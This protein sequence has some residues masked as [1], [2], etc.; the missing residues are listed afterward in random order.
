MFAT[1][2]MNNNIN[3][4]K[5]LYG[6][7]LVVA[8]V[9]IVPAINYIS[10]A[11]GFNGPTQAPPAGSG[12]LTA[13][14]NGSLGIN[15]PALNP[16]NAK[17]VITSPGAP[18]IDTDPTGNT[19]GRIIGLATNAL[20]FNMMNPDD[21]ASKAYVDAQAGGGGPVIIYGVGTGGPLP[22]NPGTGVPACS[23]LGTGYV[24]VLYSNSWNTATGQQ[25]GPPV[26]G[27]YGPFGLV[28]GTGF[29]G[30]PNSYEFE[31]AESAGNPTTMTTATYSICSSVITHY[32]PSAIPSSGTGFSGGYGALQMPA[33][34]IFSISTNNMS[35]CNT[36][37]IC[38]K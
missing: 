32:I 21:A 13:L 5:I 31:A 15:T 28:L 30:V 3:F 18:A 26:A 38:S 34:N 36:C 25:N 35:I 7:I 33:C 17:L 8:L 37:R 27:G 11:L 22:A 1:N 10:V 20:Q 19:V 24:D 6:I 23:T 16:S 29:S 14:P 12:A 2:G 4:N 9:L